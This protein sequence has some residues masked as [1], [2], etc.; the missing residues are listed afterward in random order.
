MHNMPGELGI[1]DD[2]IVVDCDDDAARGML[3]PE[4]SSA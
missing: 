1:F 4:V 3:K 2:G